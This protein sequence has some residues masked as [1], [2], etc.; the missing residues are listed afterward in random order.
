MRKGREG[1][2]VAI[3]DHGSEGVGVV[4]EADAILSL[5]G[6]AEVAGNAEPVIQVSSDRG[7]PAIGV[8]PAI[9]ARV[10]IAA[11]DLSFWRAA[12]FLGEG[13]NRKHSEQQANRY[14]LTHLQSPSRLNL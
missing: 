6:A 1:L 4:V 9:K 11:E 13:R 2:V 14:E 5:V 7:I 10:L 3:G 12:H 8:Q